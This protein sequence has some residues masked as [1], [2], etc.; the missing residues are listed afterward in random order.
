MT[1]PIPIRP[2]SDGVLY[3]D[4]KGVKKCIIIKDWDLCIEQP[5]IPIKS[6]PIP[7][8]Y[9]YMPRFNLEPL[10][11]KDVRKLEIEYIKKTRDSE[12]DD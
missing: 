8:D 5:L 11:K 3:F 7:I 4:M 6:K 10:S 9:N 12:I 2:H 1:S